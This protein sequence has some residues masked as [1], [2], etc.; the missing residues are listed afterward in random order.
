MRRKQR[1]P[2]P[3]ALYA[4][5]W[6]LAKFLWSRKEFQYYMSISWSRPSP[7]LP[8]R[9]PV[10]I[11][12][13]MLSQRSFRCMNMLEIYEAGHPSFLLVLI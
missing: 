13:D 7:P 12:S 1:L 11:K 5:Y 9:R 6:E 4:G 3:E 8:F 10:P 2:I